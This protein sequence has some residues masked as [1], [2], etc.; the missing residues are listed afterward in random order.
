MPPGTETQPVCG[1]GGKFG[2]VQILDTQL[3]K[4]PMVEVKSTSWLSQAENCLGAYWIRPCPR[5]ACAPA[6]FGPSSGGFALQVERT[7]VHPATP[8][9]AALWDAEWGVRTNVEVGFPVKTSKNMR[10]SSE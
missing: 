6:W 1:A 4:Y 8:T 10:A 9:I 5:G 7:S 3:T 2:Q